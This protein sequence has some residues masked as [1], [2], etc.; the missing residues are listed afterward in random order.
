MLAA[1]SSERDAAKSRKLV[2]LA[3]KANALAALPA[4]LLVSLASSF[5]LGVYG[6]AFR[7][8]WLTLS[9][10]AFTAAILAVQIPPIQAIISAGRVWIVFLTYISYSI[11]FLALTWLL[12][13]MGA[14]GVAI[15]RLIAYILN[16]VWV[17][18]LITRYI[19]PK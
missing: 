10:L 5:I 8:G 14:T 9:I 13:D 17:A 2:F 7:E 4:A 3:I 12:V 18:I 15:A 1:H 11:A 6:A 19:L 16:A